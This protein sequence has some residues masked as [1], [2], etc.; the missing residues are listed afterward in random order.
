MMKLIFILSLVCI[1]FGIQQLSCAEDFSQEDL[2]FGV[3]GGKIYFFQP[4]TGRIFIY[5]ITT[6]RFSHLLSLEKL[7]ENLKQSRS[8]SIIEEQEQK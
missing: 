3:D 2:Q 1:C 6:N 5:Q 7:G 4:R 8:L